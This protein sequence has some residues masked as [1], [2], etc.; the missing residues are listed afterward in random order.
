MPQLVAW[1]EHISLSDGTTAIATGAAV[2]ADPF[3]EQRPRCLTVRRQILGALFHFQSDSEALLALVDTA[4]AGLPVHRLPGAPEF[5]VTLDLLP[6][7]PGSIGA[8]PPPVRTHAS[9]GLLCGVMDACNYLM[10]SVPQHRA[11][12]VVSEDM[13][14][15]A[16]HVRYE[17][18]EFAVFLLAARGIGLVPL[19]G[20]CV[21]QRGR[22]VLLLGAS[23][24]G[25]STLAL[26]SL[27]HGLDF[28]AE[29]GVFVAP[30]SLLT[31]GVANFLHLRAE[32]LGLVDA[33]T[34]AW[35]SASP[36]IRRRSGVE[37]YEV[38]IRHG[39]AHLAAKPMQLHAVVMLSRTP[40]SVSA[41]RLVAV[42]TKQVAASLAHDQPY[43]AGQ[44]GWQR[45]VEQVQRIGMFTLHRGTHPQASVDALLQLLQ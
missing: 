38:D 45:F 23:G 13:L 2:A 37:K 17:L 5:H 33:Q 29:D 3:G 6:R 25:K 9:G 35:I 30:D 18:I 8:E 36:V 11:M 12:L 20:A 21:G 39:R 10:L 43:A 27:L 15:H 1:A 28:I 22:G 42:P 7:A 19:H 14:A 32:A 4:Y 44:P 26:H 24:A 16:Y 40:A 34:H 31:T 41:Q